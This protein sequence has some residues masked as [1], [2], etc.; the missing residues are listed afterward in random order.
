MTIEE[1]KNQIIANDEFETM[2]LSKDSREALL[3]SLRSMEACLKAADELVN[4][5]E[6]WHDKQQ[7][8]DFA[9]ET[10]AYRNAGKGE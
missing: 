5:V 10:E 2:E 7:R 9:Y 4:Q 1:F 8:D 3:S 6:R